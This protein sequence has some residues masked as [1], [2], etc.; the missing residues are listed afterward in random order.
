MASVGR[1]FLI[2][3]SLAPRPDGQTDRP[4]QS[5]QNETRAAGREKR[6]GLGESSFM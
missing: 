1:T 3:Q 6:E 2:S 5:V 4:R